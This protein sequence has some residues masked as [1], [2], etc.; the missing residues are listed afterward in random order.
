[1]PSA[2]FKSVTLSGGSHAKNC[3]GHNDR[4]N[5]PDYLL[6]PSDRGENFGDG[7]I[8]SPD[9]LIE[10]VKENE[11][12]FGRKLNGR[13]KLFREAIILIAK[14]TTEDQIKDCY[15]R[16]KSELGMTML[17][18]FEHNDEGHIDAD[19][20]TRKNH[21]IHF[22]YTF[23][24]IENHRSHKNNADVM[25]NAQDIVSESLGLERGVSKKESGRSGL[26]HQQYRR[27]KN[28]GRELD[29]EQ[30]KDQ[31]QV[32]DENK[33]LKNKYAEIRTE[34]IKT[35]AATKA[36]YAELNQIKKQ[37]KGLEEKLA[38]MDSVLTKLREEVTNSEPNWAD[39]KNNYVEM[40]LT[41]LADDYANKHS[42][43][44]KTV[45]ESD[46]TL[47]LDVS[48]KNWAHA[49]EYF[50]TE[51]EGID[52][53][54][55]KFGDFWSNAKKRIGAMLGVVQDAPQERVTRSTGLTHSSTRKTGR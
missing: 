43:Q 33:I 13:T 44:Y 3:I 31:A 8:I 27:M 16:L 17:W 20:V 12:A 7:V 50:E 49:K 53:M 18:E 11:K 6:P 41:L 37:K 25:R 39:F 15:Q 29:Q 35:Q 24:D 51:S 4:S 23:Y 52:H 32:E 10:K 30:R 36:H 28:E 48:N 1:M 14:E 26:S 2:C 45:E 42:D 46:G 54:F 38:E 21:H 9:N 22:G 19:G 40:S 5:P 55:L 47:E 34:L